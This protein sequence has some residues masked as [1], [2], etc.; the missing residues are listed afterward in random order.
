MNVSVPEKKKDILRHLKLLLLTGG[1]TAASQP[2]IDFH[3]SILYLFDPSR[4]RMTFMNAQKITEHL[5]YG[6]DE[7][8]TMEESLANLVFKDDMD[9]VNAEI[10]K[11]SFLDDDDDYTYDC[12]L[13][14]K[15]GD[16]RYFR[17]RGTVLRRNSDG[18]P[19]S[20]LFVAEDITEKSN[21]EKEIAA[22]RKLLDDTED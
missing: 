7:I 9:M 4:K 1:I 15:K 17:T 3:P 14:H 10:E 5:G 12:R 8:A 11:F 20:M 19:E 22:L 6:E 18:K 2:I 13:N 16:W 21:N